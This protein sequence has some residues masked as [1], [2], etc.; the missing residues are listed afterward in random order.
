MKRVCD[1][2]SLAIKK[3]GMAGCAFCRTPLAKNHAESFRLVQARVDK[4]DT[5]A[6][7]FVGDQYSSGK[8]TRQ[9]E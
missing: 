4:K 3:R 8:K 2:C 9:L 7:K 5:K 6:I 1:G